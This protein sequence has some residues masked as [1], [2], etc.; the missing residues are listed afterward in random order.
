MIKFVCTTRLSFKAA[1]SLIRFTKK[2]TLSVIE[3]NVSI[4]S[5]LQRFSVDGWIEA[6][7]CGAGTGCEA[8]T[9]CEA[10]TDCETKTK[11]IL[12]SKATTRLVREWI[13]TWNICCIISCISCLMIDW[14]W[15]EDDDWLTDRSEKMDSS[16]SSWDDWV[17]G[18]AAF[19]LWPRVVTPDMIEDENKVSRIEMFS[20]RKKRWTKRANSSTWWSV[21]RLI[22]VR[23]IKLNDH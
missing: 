13:C 3:S 10:E 20:S 8:E 4:S 14:A 19:L 15:D 2:W 12:A 1:I 21:T 6:T 16:S 23:G 9:N 18:W 17:A 11:L 7:D 5:I 22:C